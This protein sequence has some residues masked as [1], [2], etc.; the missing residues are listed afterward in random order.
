MW[1]RAWQGAGDGAVDLG[2]ALQDSEGS[3][4]YPSFQRASLQWLLTHLCVLMGQPQEL[5][6]TRN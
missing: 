6:E 3:P 4:F 1:P 2:R 5:M